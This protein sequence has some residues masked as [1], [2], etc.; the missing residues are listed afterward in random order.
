MRLGKKID[1]EELVFSK[2]D[3]WTIYRYY[4]GDFTIGA[5]FQNPCTAKQDTPSFGIYQKDSKYY[6]GDFAVPDIHGDSIAL[7]GQMHH[8]TYIEALE[9]VAKDFG[10][11]AGTNVYKEITKQYKKPAIED[12]KHSTIH[13]T[14]AWWNKESL[15]YWKDYGITLEQLKREEVYPVAEWYLNRSKQVIE[16]GELCFCYRYPEGF[17]IYYPHRKGSDKWKS[18]IPTKL[19]EGLE[20]LNGH[21][22]VVITKSKKD[23]LTLESILPADIGI[24]SVQN[25]SVA[26]F[27]PEL[28]QILEGRT[29]HLSFDADPPGKKA[30]LKINSMYP[31]WKHINVPDWFYEERGLKDW[32]EVMLLEGPE[33]IVH[34]F[35]KKKLIK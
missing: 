16:E 34:H 31:H 2:L 24:I 23:R 10:L 1:W 13:V 21:Q 29:I 9:R 18:N 5:V 35:K 20:K 33:V 17:K 6:H 19:V 25:E 3:H 27:T 12:R 15:Q 30:S 28:I 11:C 7:V 4:V 14:A 22:Q 32:A 26:A 8:L